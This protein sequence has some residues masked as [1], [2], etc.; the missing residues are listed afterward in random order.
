[1][2]SMRPNGRCGTPAVL[3]DSGGCPAR[4][5][6][7]TLRWPI[8]KTTLSRWTYGGYAIAITPRCIDAAYSFQ[9]GRRWDGPPDGNEKSY[10][11]AMSTELSPLCKFFSPARIAVSAAFAGLTRLRVFFSYSGHF[12]VDFLRRVAYN[13]SRS[14]Q[15]S[16]N[17]RQ[18]A[19]KT[20]KGMRKPREPRLEPEPGRPP[21]NTRAWRSRPKDL[22]PKGCNHDTAHRQEKRRRGQA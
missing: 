15:G 8:T 12:F 6:V 10:I 14:R 9:S 1:M 4:S 19:R 20:P 7:A 22:L 21:K 17:Q 3:E 16:D 18:A 5:V 11:P 13:Y 2:R